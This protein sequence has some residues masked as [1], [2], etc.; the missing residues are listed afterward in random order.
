MTL[1]G[2]TFDLENPTNTFFHGDCLEGMKRFPDR[3][4]D[5]AIVDPPYGSEFINDNKDHFGGGRNKSYEYGVER[6][7]GWLG[8]SIRR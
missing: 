1:Y 8:K 4:F 5:L 2:Q 3:Y 7:G 6:R